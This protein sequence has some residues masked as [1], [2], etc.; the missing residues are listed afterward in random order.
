MYTLTVENTKGEQLRLTQNESIYQIASIDGLTPSKANINTTTIA[1]MNGARFKSSYIQARNVVITVAVQG[2]VEKNRLHLYNFFGTGQWCKLYYSN[3]SRDVYCEGYCETVDGSLFVMSQ[4]IQISILCPDPYFRSL[5]EIVSDISKE[6]ANFE[7]PFS[8]DEEGKEFSIIDEHREA[9]VYNPGEIAC[10]VIIRMYAEAD[11]IENP[12]IR[13]VLTGEYLGVE[14]TLDQ[15]DVLEINTNKG[16]KKITKYIDA[17]PQN[18]IN[19]LMNGSTWFQLEPGLN[20]F[21]YEA[22]S[23]DL[24]LKIEFLHNI[25]Y[26]GV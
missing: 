21:Y 25:L 12:I 7:F 2:E 18:E 1:G 3:S 23:L 15:G 4:R 20:R 10:G 13:N 22:D 26:E 17:V 5:T 19:G 9:D 11:G 8:I 16:Q 6:F 14:V 24:F